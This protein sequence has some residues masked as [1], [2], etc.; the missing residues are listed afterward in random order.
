MSIEHQIID[1][2]NQLPKHDLDSNTIDELGRSN[3]PGRKTLSGDLKVYL[4]KIKN[5]SYRLS[6]L[7]HSYADSVSRD[8]AGLVEKHK[9]LSENHYS[10]GQGIGSLHLTIE[11]LTRENGELKAQCQRLLLHYNNAVESKTKMH[12]V[13]QILEEQVHQLNSRLS[14]LGQKSVDDFNSRHTGH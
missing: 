3:I 8:H 5:L 4:G 14:G 6:D 1:I 11:G 10:M 13:N 12:Q 7:F 9:S 2:I